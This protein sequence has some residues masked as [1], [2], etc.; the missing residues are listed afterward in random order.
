MR[1]TDTTPITIVRSPWLLFLLLAGG[2]AGACLVIAASS[3]FTRDPAVLAAAMLCDLLGV[4]P[5]AYWWFIVRRRLAAARTLIPVVIL[6]LLAAHQALPASHRGVLDW[7]RFLIAPAELTLAGYIIWKVRSILRTP[8]RGG[9]ADIVETIERVLEPALGH[10]PAARLIAAE[11]AILYYAFGVWKRHGRREETGD[12]PTFIP[13]RST[14]ILVVLGVVLAIETAGMHLLV[15]RW[16]DTAA[17]VLT[18]LSAYT[19]L[20]VVG[21]FRALALRP[22]IVTREALR[23]RV[24]LRFSATVPWTMVESARRA[25]WRDAANKAKDCANLASPATPNVLI[26]FAEPI[27]A[28]GYFGMERSVRT[29]LLAVEDP[30]G[31]LARM[32]ASDG[33]WSQ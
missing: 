26:T 23:L 19:L 13:V 14:P 18:G 21:D 6:C 20:W 25:S 4:V 29:V 5:L 16:S 3:A 33:A 12:G 24:G 15:S 8:P 31:L 7:I 32:N 28:R 30:N 10:R 27:A 11:M 2:V 1:T 17:W 22:T 9:S